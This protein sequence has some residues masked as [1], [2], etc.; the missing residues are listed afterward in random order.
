M[1]SVTFPTLA[2][3]V[4]QIALGIAVF[5]ANRRR[6]AHQC[7]LLL[8]LTIA[9]WLASLYL[10]FIAK[11]PKM[12]EFAIRQASA[13]AV[14]YLASLNLLRLSV[15]QQM[16]GWRSLIRNS[17]IWLLLTI[18]IATLCQTQLFLQ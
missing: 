12:A 14:F 9:A 17:R 6:L 13:S 1:N 2:A 18:S 11:T 10:A 16:S 4:L 5:Q 15:R 8:S 7:F 3:L